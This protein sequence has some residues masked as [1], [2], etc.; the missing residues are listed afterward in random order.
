MSR[1]LDEMKKELLHDNNV[2]I[3]ITMLSDKLI[4]IEKVAEYSR[5]PIDE[6]KALA[7]QLNATE[8]QHHA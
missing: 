5:L 4:N 8:R 1:A 6:V 7:K 3:A 2:E